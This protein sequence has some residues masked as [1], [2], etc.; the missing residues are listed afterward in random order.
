MN[1]RK[2]ISFFLVLAVLSVILVVVHRFESHKIPGWQAELE[3][4]L[5]IS[6]RFLSETRIISV[7]EAASPQNFVPDQVTAVPTGWTWEGISE[8]PLPTAVQ[9]V[10]LESYVLDHENLMGRRRWQVVLVGFHDD[11]LWHSGWVVH[12]INYEVSGQELQEMLVRLGCDLGLDNL[13]AVY[14]TYKLEL[15]RAW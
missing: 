9:C 13:Q 11:G 7:V 3:R 4:Y 6:Q 1:S 5:L 8:I 12:E 10:R 14:P 2:L 15:G